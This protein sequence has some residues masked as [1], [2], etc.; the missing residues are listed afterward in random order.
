MDEILRIL[1]MS[2]MHKEDKIDRIGDFDSLCE[3]VWE[4]DKLVKI[5]AAINDDEINNYNTRE[6]LFIADLAYQEVLAK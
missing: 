4:Q 6:L 2:L 5:F 3:V 1:F